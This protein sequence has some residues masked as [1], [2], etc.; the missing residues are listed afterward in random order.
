MSLQ[1]ST[2]NADQRFKISGWQKSQSLHS[3]LVYLIFKLALQGVFFFNVF[4][5]R[6]L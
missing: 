5:S 6:L 3:C 4:V 1:I 2:P